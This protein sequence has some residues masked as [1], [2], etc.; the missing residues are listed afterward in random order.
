VD[1]VYV[2]DRGVVLGEE[3]GMA[4]GEWRMA[5]CEWEI[6]ERLSRPG[7]RRP[8]YLAAAVG[9]AMGAGALKESRKASA[10]V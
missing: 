3:V 10:M 5:N 6:V 4:S 2:W 9:W 8:R 1:A 7:A